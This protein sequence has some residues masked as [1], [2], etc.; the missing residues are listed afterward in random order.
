MTWSR[1]AQNG[2]LSHF[3]DPD[4]DPLSLV[5]VMNELKEFYEYRAALMKKYQH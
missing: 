2:K 1:S 3:V 5:I 4:R